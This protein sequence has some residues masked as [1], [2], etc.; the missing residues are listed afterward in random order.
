[1]DLISKHKVISPVELPSARM[2]TPSQSAH[3]AVCRPIAA[4]K[5]D[6]MCKD[7]VSAPRTGSA[8]TQEGNV[9][10]SF[11]GAGGKEI[12]VDCPKVGPLQASV[13]ARFTALP[14]LMGVNLCN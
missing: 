2:V 13:N 9:T 14:Y 6:A 3:R 8:S 11:L 7:L 10:V 4:S 12:A 1:M 5:A